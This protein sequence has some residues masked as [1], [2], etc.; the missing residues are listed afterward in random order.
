MLKTLKECLRRTFHGQDAL[1]DMP[2]SAAAVLKS[3]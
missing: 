2:W 3:R 1:Y